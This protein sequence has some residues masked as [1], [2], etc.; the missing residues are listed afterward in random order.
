M[1]YLDGI[2]ITALSDSAEAVRAVRATRPMSAAQARGLIAASISALERANT[3]DDEFIDVTV[4][5]IDLIGQLAN[6]GKRLEQVK[7]GA[8]P[9]RAAE[10][11]RDAVCDA[12]DEFDA[13]ADDVPSLALQRDE[14]VDE[15]VG[16]AAM[17]GPPA[18]VTPAEAS[19][20]L[21]WARENPWRAG[22]VVA[23]AALAAYGALSLIVRRR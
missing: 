17:A 5:R 12:I 19:R 20:A 2:D 18:Q 21:S 8:I 10:I 23:V 3:E 15:V 4:K 13:A 16:V 9:E 7:E 6:M 11:L 14:I 1:S 22:A